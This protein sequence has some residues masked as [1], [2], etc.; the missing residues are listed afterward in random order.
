[1]WTTILAVGLNVTIFDLPSELPIWLL[2][3]PAFNI[4]RIFYIL[5]MS[6]GY[7]SCIG[8]MSEI[9]PEL[10]KCLIILFL[11]SVVYTFV[12]IYLYEVIP[13]QFGVSKNP[14]F[15]LNFLSKEKKRR[16]SQNINLSKCFILD[17]LILR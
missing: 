5:T 17:Y 14:F 13:Q 16:N 12:G 6:C 4:C 8:S 3:Y 2:C 15:C 11:S 1:L 10:T 9:T 7:S